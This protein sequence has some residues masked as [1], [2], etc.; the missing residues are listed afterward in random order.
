MAPIR[1]YLRITKYSVLECRIY[2][3]NPALAHSWLLNP[4]N[5]MLAK[6]IEAVRPLVL[7]KL[8]EE[9][10]RAQSKKSSKKRSI[11]DVVIK[12]D[13]EVSVFLAETDTRHSLL[14]KQKHF[15]DKVQTKLK[16]N[17]SKLTGESREAPI[18][19]DV[20]AAL[21]REAADDDDV[22]VLR[23]DDSEDQEVNLNDIPT[24]D[25]TDVISDSANRRSK[26]QRQQ[27]SGPKNKGGTDDEAQVVA[28]DLSDD[29]G[30][31]I[32]DS[33]DAGSE[34][35]PERKRR[36]SKQPAAQ[37]EE[38]DDKKKLAMDIS[39]EGF[40]IY[41]RVLCLVVKRRDVEKTVTGPSS[42]KAL[43]AQPGGQA[44]MEN[45][46]TSTQLPE[47]A[48]GEDDAV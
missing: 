13:F 6:V 30:L 21:L 14:H 9:R 27:S 39:Y 5:P 47:A 34:G 29:D 38:R 44:M 32:G 12:D 17:S 18:D 11:K 42:G 41:G 43:T 40:A 48:V 46:I 15:R 7:P 36:K 24:V 35:P 20:E 22:P 19:V 23:E 45:W 16:S 3:D 1:R 33:D 2:L 26:R 25:E 28:S 8:R 4:R 31:F 10:E 37:E